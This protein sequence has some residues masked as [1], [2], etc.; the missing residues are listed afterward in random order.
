MGIFQDAQ[1]L[2]PPPIN[3]VGRDFALLAVEVQSSQERPAEEHTKDRADCTH[4]RIQAAA[5]Q[6]GRDT[7]GGMSMPP[8]SSSQAWTGIPAKG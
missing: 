2:D 8:P 7:P 5:Q 3:E 6:E 1:D 4:A